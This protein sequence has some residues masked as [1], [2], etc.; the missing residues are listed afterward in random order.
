MRY[1]FEKPKVNITYVNN[2][3]LTMWLT[4][5][6]DGCIAL[7]CYTVYVGKVA[8]SNFAFRRYFPTLE[9]SDGD[10]HLLHPRP[11]MYLNPK[12]IYFDME[13]QLFK[14]LKSG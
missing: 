2:N 8:E 10:L 9:C 13:L 12:N 6:N 4:Y 11:L 1:Y 5:A 14:T 7:I 3:G